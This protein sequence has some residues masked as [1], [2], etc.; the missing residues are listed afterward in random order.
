MHNLALL[1]ENGIPEETAVEPDEEDSLDAGRLD[2][3]IPEDPPKGVS[4]ALDPFQMYLHDIR[5]YHLLTREG[6][7]SLPPQFF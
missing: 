7:H 5:K 6:N 1:M 4:L 2:L 3:D